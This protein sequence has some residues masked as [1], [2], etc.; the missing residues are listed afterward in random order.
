MS[1]NEVIAIIGQYP[2]PFYWL[3]ASA[4]WAKLIF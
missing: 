4:A 2:E 3:L 1:A